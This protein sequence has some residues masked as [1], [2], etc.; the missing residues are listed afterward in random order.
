[1]ATG[2]AD[3]V[4]VTVPLHAAGTVS[5]HGSTTVTGYV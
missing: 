1:M 4:S 5:V 3:A 2:V